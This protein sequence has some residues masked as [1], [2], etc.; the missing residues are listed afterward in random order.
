[1]IKEQTL[2]TKEIMLKEMKHDLEEKDQ[3]HD[4]LAERLSRLEQDCTN[5]ISDKKD[6]QDGL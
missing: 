4:K 2:R 1:M 6:M 3:I 5:M